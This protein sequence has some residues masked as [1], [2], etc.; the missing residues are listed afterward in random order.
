MSVF[1]RVVRADWQRDRERLRQIRTAVFVDEQRVPP[2]LEWDGLDE[3]CLHVLAEDSRG[4]AIGT[5]RLLPDGRIGRMAVLPAWR[6]GGVG[7]A[8]LSE[9]LRC[10][11]QEGLTEVVLNA[12]THALGFYAHHGF[13]AEGELFLDAG[14]EHRRMRRKLVQATFHATGAGDRTAGS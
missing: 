3:S 5:G 4:T 6:R 9:L 13:A 1:F 12:Q 10:A 11:L 14:I 2:E 7:G 8:I